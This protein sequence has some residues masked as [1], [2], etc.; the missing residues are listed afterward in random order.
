MARFK[1]VAAQA[2]AQLL[3]AAQMREDNLQ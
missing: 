1:S 3:A 2:K